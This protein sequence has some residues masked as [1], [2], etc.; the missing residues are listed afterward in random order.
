MS[1]LRQRLY[2]RRWLFLSQLLFLSSKLSFLSSKLL[3]LSSKLLSL[4]QWWFP[5][6][7]PLSFLLPVTITR[8]QR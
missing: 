5:G 8:E 2:L 6:P 3:S 1:C 4:K 7:H